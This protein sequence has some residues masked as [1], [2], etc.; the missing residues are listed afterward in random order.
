ME[1]QDVDWKNEIYRVVE[2]EKPLIILMSMLLKS[3][4][5]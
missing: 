5:I 4:A 3:N 1:Q 2:K